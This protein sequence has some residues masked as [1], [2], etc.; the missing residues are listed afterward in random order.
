MKTRRPS[1]VLLLASLIAGCVPPT[2]LSSFFRSRAYIVE[3]P[4]D[5]QA[6]QLVIEM[7]GVR[8]SKPDAPMAGL[9]ILRSE[10]GA[11]LTCQFKSGYWGQDGVGSC[12]DDAGHV[13]DMAFKR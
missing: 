6:R 3:R 10:G 4:H 8:Y 11:S 9:V 12:T 1:L 5:T 13:H 7:G 2:S